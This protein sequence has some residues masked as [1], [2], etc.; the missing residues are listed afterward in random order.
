MKMRIEYMLKRV[1]KRKR[2]ESRPLTIKVRDSYSDNNDLDLSIPTVKNICKFGKRLDQLQRLYTK[3]TCRFKRLLQTRE[4]IQ[5]SDT[6]T[7]VRS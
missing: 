6:F 5:H 2:G 4:E 1:T 7:S 3:E